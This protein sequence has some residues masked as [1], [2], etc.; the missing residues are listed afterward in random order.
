MFFLFSG[1]LDSPSRSRDR[2][3]TRAF[4]LGWSSRIY[5]TPTGVTSQDSV[6]AFTFPSFLPDSV[7]TS[8]LVE[9][10]ADVERGL[11]A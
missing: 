9:L 3:T 11:A 8:S 2:A 6:N 4:Q 10:A 7:K 5:C 1:T